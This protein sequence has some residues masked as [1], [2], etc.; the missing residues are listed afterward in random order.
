MVEHAAVAGPAAAGSTTGAVIGAKISSIFD[1]TAEAARSEDDPDQQTTA[2]TIAPAAKPP[3]GPMA[4][5]RSRPKGARVVWKRGM[6]QALR[7]QP[8]FPPSPVQAPASSPQAPRLVTREDVLRRLQAVTAG[9]QRASVIQTLGAP[10]S[11][12]AMA[13]DGGGYVERMRYRAAGDDVAIIEVR[14]GVVASVAILE[15]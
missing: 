2:V 12:L 5:P 11:T 7:N 3:G 14:D 6:E 8:A 10:A 9:E 4:A 13:G 15:R 1:A